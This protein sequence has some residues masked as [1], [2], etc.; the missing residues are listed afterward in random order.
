[1]NTDEIYMAII[2]SAISNMPPEQQGL[3]LSLI[4]KL[5]AVIDT[6]PDVEARSAAVAY[7]GGENLLRNPNAT[8]PNT[9]H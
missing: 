5:K 1:M 6:C 4:A 7:I 8:T 9:S 2:Q 3:T